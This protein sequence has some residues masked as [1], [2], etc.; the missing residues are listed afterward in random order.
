MQARANHYM[1]MSLLDSQFAAL[2]A[3]GADERG[4]RLDIHASPAELVEA[5]AQRFGAVAPN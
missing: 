3:L 4:I 2:E 1:P 5:A